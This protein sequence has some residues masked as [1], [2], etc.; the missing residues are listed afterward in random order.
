MDNRVNLNTEISKYYKSFSGT[1]TLAFIMMPGSSPVVIGSLTTISYSMYRN[2]KPVINIGR[3]NINGV[4]RGSRIFAGTM[5]FTL[6]NQ[7]WLKEL[8]EQPQLSWLSGFKELKVD[9]LPLFD[10]MIVSANEY[11]NY[12]NMYIYGIDF[13][14]EAQTISVEDLFTENVFSFVA[15]DI[16][17]FKAGNIRG[18][19]VQK[20]SSNGNVSDSSQRFFVLDSSTANFD[21][22]AVL[23]KEFSLAKINQLK[24]PRVYNLSRDLYYSPSKTIIGNDVAEI[25]ELLN[26]THLVQ[27]PINGIFDD[28]MDKAVRLYQ[29]LIKDDI[30]GIVDNK[31]YN[32]LINKV[33]GDITRL[34]V[35]VNKY[36]AYVYKDPDYRAD[37]VDIKKY[38]EQVPIYE[39]IS[40]N[41]N[42]GNPGDNNNTD[43][44]T[45]HR[46]YKVNS[47]Y[48]AE[49]DLYS[50]YYTGSV[51]EFPV[52]Q[53]GDYS[54]YVTLIQT[55]LSD[56]Y[57]SFN[58]ITG[59][60]DY[61]TQAQI[62]RLQSENG[63][64]SS[65]IVNNDTWL[66][67]QSLS[68]NI[69]NKVS[70][71]NF[72]IE[73][74]TLP[75]VYNVS[76]KDVIN[77]ISIFNVN[78]SCDNYTNI[79]SSAI[80]IYDDNNSETF[81]KTTTIKDKTKISL[82]DFKNAFVYNPKYGKEPKQVDYIIY[83]YNKKPYK[84]TIMYS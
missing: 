6:I 24:K 62:K 27:I 44:D 31:L 10:I 47:G 73:I 48:I 13:T 58:T 45:F 41:G 19:V 40:G 33:T 30:D 78:V 9:E 55:A 5:V 76:N 65:G 72:N 36:G 29:S 32:D 28:S 68:G 75:G 69:A 66:L 70:D 82:S 81:T 34:G 4:T 43:D 83:P 12:V 37:I 1:D 51:I 26:K 52:I 18:S 23:D 74:G 21:D 63:M 20:G 60:Y 25:Q 39:I 50:S 80:A 17:T 8:Q 38:Q 2:K 35:V 61:E 11:G 84:W 3:T 67:L 15:R 79:K 46:W 14:D 16:S 22:L 7:H 54:A 77:Q 53:Y 59:T 71:D 49:E 64:D 56:I 42:S 57:P